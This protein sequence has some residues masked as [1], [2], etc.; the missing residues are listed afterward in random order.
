[1][2]RR[3]LKDGIHK[4]FNLEKVQVKK[5]NF[6]LGFSGMDGSNFIGDLIDGKYANLTI[7]RKMKNIRR[8]L[9]NI[10]D[11]KKVLIKQEK[12]FEKEI[13]DLSKAVDSQMRYNKDFDKAIINRKDDFVK[14]IAIHKLKGEIDILQIKEIAGNMSMMLDAKWTAEQLI[15]EALILIKT[16]KFITRRVPTYT[17]SPSGHITI[18]GTREENYEVKH[19]NP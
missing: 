18:T 5:L 15:L 14:T 8:K 17:A 12:K 10:R 7:S 16:S 19:G 4:L 3:K 2:A 9:E 1:M 11:D 6:M 13:L